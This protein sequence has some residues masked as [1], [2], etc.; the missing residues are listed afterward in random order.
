MSGLKNE[1]KK[2]KLNSHQLWGQNDCSREFGVLTLKTY[3]L[4]ILKN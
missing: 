3:I 2:T 4:K 1:K